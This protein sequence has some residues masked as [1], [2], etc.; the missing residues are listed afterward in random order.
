MEN[1]QVDKLEAYCY[2]PGC[3][4]TQKLTLGP[5]ATLP[6]IRYNLD[7]CEKYSVHVCSRVLIVSKNVGYDR[8]DM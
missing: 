6:K 3:N 2:C 8:Y 4:L 5:R 7:N 1:H